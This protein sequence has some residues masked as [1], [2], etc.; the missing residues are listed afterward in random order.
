[1][2]HKLHEF[3]HGVTADYDDYQFSKGTPSSG[4]ADGEFDDNDDHLTLGLVVWRSTIVYRGLVNFATVDLSAFYFEVV[5]D[6]LYADATDSL[7]RRSTQTVLRHT[8]DALTA[9]LAPI[10][11]FT[12][13]DIHRY[14]SSRRWLPHHAHATRTHA[15]RHGRYQARRTGGCGGAQRVPPRVAA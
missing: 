7:R 4:G 13:Q 14:Y 8:L 15:Q 2:L 6:R 11:P 12:A 10:A 5:K 9:A 1:M 3:S